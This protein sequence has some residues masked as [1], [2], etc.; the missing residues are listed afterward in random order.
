MKWI[1]CEN[2]KP[3]KCVITENNNGE[4][5]DVVYTDVVFKIEDTIKGILYDKTIN[6][7]IDT[8]E[9]DGYK[10]RSDGYI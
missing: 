9:V 1:A 4:K 6:V 2:L 5:L 8:G 10:V 7:R 3:S